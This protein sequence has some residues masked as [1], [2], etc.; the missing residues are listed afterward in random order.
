M[1]VHGKNSAAH[2][3]DVDE[4]F[5]V[6]AMS[7]NIDDTPVLIP[8]SVD[9]FEIPNRDIIDHLFNAYLNIVHPSSP[10]I[11]KV[12]FIWQYQAFINRPHMK[13]G[14]KW[15]AILN[16]IFAISGK[17]SHLIQAD[18]G[19]DDRDHLTYFTRA[20]LLA[21]NSESIFN[22]LDLRQIQVSGLVAFIC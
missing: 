16:M 2:L 3:L 1:F 12:N 8:E 11:G 6:N 21:L 9:A 5:T 4:G 15:L 19:G 20:R 14:N 13:P 17:Y 22:H 18:W 10:I 7:Y